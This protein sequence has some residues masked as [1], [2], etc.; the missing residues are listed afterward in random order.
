[1]SLHGLT[2]PGVAYVKDRDMEAPLTKPHGL[3][4]SWNRCGRAV[5]VLQKKEFLTIRNIHVHYT[6][7]RV[8]Q[9]YSL[10]I[11]HKLLPS[12]QRAYWK[13]SEGGTELGMTLSLSDM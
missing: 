4:L 6:K 1:M 11:A 10:F 8:P 5:V 7:F 3:K 2:G 13:T 9:T 12:T